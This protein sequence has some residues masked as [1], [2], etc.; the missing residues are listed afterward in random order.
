LFALL[1]GI[2]TY[3]SHDIRNLTGAVADVQAFEKYLREKLQTPKS[4]I[5]TLKNDDATRKAII[6][7]ITHLS[8]DTRIQSGDAILIYYAG[9]GARAKAPKEWEKFCNYT[10]LIMPHDANKKEDN[11]SNLGSVDVISDWELAYHLTKIAKA[12]GDNIVSSCLI[13]PIIR[14]HICLR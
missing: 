5:K 4:Q 10:E 2:D 13:S 9:H 1:I 14:A 12:K 8:T 11:E 3:K 6:E 7:E